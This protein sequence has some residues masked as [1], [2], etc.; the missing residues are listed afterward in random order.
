MSGSRGKASSVVRGAAQRPAG[1]GLRGLGLRGPQLSAAGLLLLLLGSIAGAVELRP[2]AGPTCTVTQEGD[3]VTRDASS[4]LKRRP[5]TVLEEH[6]T[7]N[8]VTDDDTLTVLLRRGR[9]VVLET[10][11]LIHADQ[12]F[13]FVRKLGR[14]FKG[15][16]EIHQTHTGGAVTVTVD[17]RA[18]SIP[19]LQSSPP[20]LVFADGKP[21]PRFHVKRAAARLVQASSAA[22]ATLSSCTPNSGIAPRDQFNDPFKDE[23]ERCISGCWGVAFACN[24]LTLGTGSVIGFFDSSLGCGGRLEKCVDLCNAVGHE[25]CHVHCGE[26]CCDRDAVAA[27]TI[28]AGATPDNAGTCCERGGACGPSC[29]GIGRC[30]DPATG[31]CC[32]PGQSGCGNFCCGGPNGSHCADPATSL[33]CPADA[34]GCGFACCPAGQRCAV[35][36]D[37]FDLIVC[38]VCPPGKTGPACGN[39]CC[40]AD[41]VCSAGICCRPDSLCGGSCCDPQFCLNGN[42][43]CAP[44]SHA[45]GGSCCAPLQGCCNGQC[46]DGP[47]VGGVCCAP[48]RACG[49]ACCPDGWAC[50]DAASGKCEQCSAGKKGCAPVAGNPLCCPTGTDC[51]ASGDCCAPPAVCCAPPGL[52]PGCYPQA[53]CV[54]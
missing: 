34:E 13:D 53:S 10:S 20:S 31:L 44:P 21:A 22:V 39:T 54:N 30:G 16:K 35:P 25:C 24:A 42:N 51:C 23:C 3:V 8:P 45:C 48:E 4:I 52:A 29:C 47:C 7:R 14:G 41:E 49:S 11:L 43:C 37:D 27:D 50:T 12:S 2:A 17:G 19:A 18:V 36:S 32:G 38:N 1:A 6:R 40:G 33:C 5:K 46:C 26:E 9:H 28:C 15:I